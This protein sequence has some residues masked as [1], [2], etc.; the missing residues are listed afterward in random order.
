MASKKTTGKKK[1][2]ISDLPKT[3]KKV[4]R[5]SGD[6]ADKVRGGTGTGTKGGIKPQDPTVY[7]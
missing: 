3:S 2:Q 7:G 1:V 5:V 4:D 6:H